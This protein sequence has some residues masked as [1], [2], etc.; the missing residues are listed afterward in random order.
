MSRYW[1]C[2]LFKQ[3]ILICLYS[4]LYG[5]FLL[6][7]LLH[8]CS[9]CTEHFCNMIR[10]DKKF[11]TGRDAGGLIWYFWTEN[12]SIIFYQRSSNIIH[13]SISIST[14]SSDKTWSL[15]DIKLLLSWLFS[16]DISQLFK[17]LKKYFSA[18]FLRICPKNQW[19]TKISFYLGIVYLLR[20]DF[21]EEGGV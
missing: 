8:Y 13:I 18:A 11:C 15:G 2:F 3:V 19:L 17:F 16:D 5:I 9:I 1:V 6:Q 21:R 14:I 4:V 7:L 10:C 20:S 12:S